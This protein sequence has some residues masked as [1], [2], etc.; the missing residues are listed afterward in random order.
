MSSSVPRILHATAMMAVA[1]LLYNSWILGYWLNPAVAHRG[2]ASEFEGL[3]QPY[4]WVFIA[5]DVMCGLLVTAVCWLLWQQVRR[6]KTAKAVFGGLV[7]FAAGTIID[8]LLPMHCSPSLQSCPSF[9]QDHLL[10]VHGLASIAAALGLFAS[11]IVLWWHSRRDH[12][13]ILLLAGY[14]LFGAF[15]LIDALA[16]THHNWSQHYYLLLCGAWLAFLPAAIRRNPY[17]A[18]HPAENRPRA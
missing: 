18:T 1:G 9:T 2:L 12:V 14:V 11:L 6:G 4:N 15:S 13:L 16:P 10:L 5:G 7:V 3:H 17:L 8:T